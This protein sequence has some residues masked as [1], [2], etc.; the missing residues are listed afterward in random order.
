M[1]FFGFGG[2]FGEEEK[3]L[4]GDG[5]GKRD[6]KWWLLIRRETKMRNGGFLLIWVDG[7]WCFFFL[8]FFFWFVFVVVVCCGSSRRSVLE[9]G[10]THDKK[11]CLEKVP[12][13]KTFVE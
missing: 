9:K 2:V 11:A 1:V 5:R 6:G 10:D 4:V 7:S 3:G 13:A 8:L 12:A